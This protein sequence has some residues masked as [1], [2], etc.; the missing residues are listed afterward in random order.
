MVSLLAKN[1]SAYDRVLAGAS[2]QNILIHINS[3]PSKVSNQV[4]TFI[5]HHGRRFQE[6][7]LP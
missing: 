5:D 7:I 1:E 3:D 6:L 2:Y 4:S